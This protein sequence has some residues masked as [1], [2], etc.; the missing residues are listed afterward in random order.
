[1][2]DSSFFRVTPQRL[3]IYRLAENR[4]K[5]LRERA[6]ISKISKSRTSK[7]AIK[8]HGDQKNLNTSHHNSTIVISSASNFPLKF[9]Q[10]NPRSLSFIFHCLPFLAALLLINPHIRCLPR[11]AIL[12]YQ[13]YHRAQ[14]RQEISSRQLNND[15]LKGRSEG[16]RRWNR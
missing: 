3:C 14:R 11:S 9:L 13:N 5:P 6:R 2:S 1:M 7:N 4:K 15:S 12:F 8:M 16:G 10:I